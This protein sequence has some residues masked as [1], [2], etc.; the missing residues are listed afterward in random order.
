MAA[1][2]LQK[3]ASKKKKLY[4]WLEEPT[5]DWIE[6]ASERSGYN[7]SE[8]VEMAVNE[9]RKK[10]KLPVPDQEPTQAPGK[11]DLNND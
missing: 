2:L 1:R 9:F 7:K 10:V 4:V 3:P 5:A 8:I 11:E 6:D